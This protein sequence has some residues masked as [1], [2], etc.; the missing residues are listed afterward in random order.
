VSLPTLPQTSWYCALPLHERL[1]LW[2]SSAPA[3]TNVERGEKRLTR[4]RAQAPFPA[5][6]AFEQRLATDGVSQDELRALLGESIEAASGR[7]A[8]EPAWARAVRESFGADAS[9]QSRLPLPPPWAHQPGREFWPMVE[10]L[11]RRVRARLD[12]AAGELLRAHPQSPL[13]GSALSELLMSCL[14]RDL[15]ATAVRTLVLELNVA[16]VQGHLQGQSPGARF[17]EFATRISAPGHALE[18]FAEYPVL[19]Q[20][21]VSYIDAWCHTTL[22]LLERLCQDWP[23][24]ARTFDCQ[25][26]SSLSTSPGP[27]PWICT[28]R[29]CC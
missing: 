24:I 14:P 28:S 21:L 3:P 26:D 9:G 17:Q 2:R 18:L 23:L 11:I 22:E 13:A 8:Q 20:K 29:S 16:R 19:A 25:E 15:L 4:W 12:L 5:G 6:R 10:P 7:C 1:E 27:W